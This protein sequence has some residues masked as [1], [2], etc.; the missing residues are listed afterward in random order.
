MSDASSS[1]LIDDLPGAPIDRVTEPIARFLHI[2]AL[3]LG[4]A[5]VALIGLI[6]FGNKGSLLLVWEFLG[7]IFMLNIVYAGMV[8]FM[9]RSVKHAKIELE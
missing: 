4:F 5:G 7:L 3:G 1:E 8:Y 9:Q 2:E 6:Q